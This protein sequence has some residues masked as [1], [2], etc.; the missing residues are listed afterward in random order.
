MIK[1]NKTLKK[2]ISET[3]IEKLNSKERKKFIDRV[4]STKNK[5]DNDLKHFFSKF[6]NITIDYLI[7]PLY[8]LKNNKTLDFNLSPEQIT[9]TIH[10][11]DQI[12]KKNNELTIYTQLLMINKEQNLN[13]SSEQIT[14]FLEKTDLFIQ[15]DNGW[16]TPMLILKY[17][18]DQNLNLSPNQILSIIE[19]SDLSIQDKNGLTL[20]MHLLSNNK[21][22]NLNLSP[23]QII[24]IIEK[25]DPTIKTKIEYS[26]LMF[27]L[28]TNKIQ[29][30]NLS[31]NQIF[32]LLKKTKIQD[33][34]II[35][36]I[37][38]NNKI[39]NFN[40]SSEQ[41]ST[42]IKKTNPLLLNNEIVT[43]FFL[44]LGEQFELSEEDLHKTIK[45]FNS[46]IKEIN[47][48][49]KEKINRILTHYN[50]KENIQINSTKKTTTKL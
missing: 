39:Q 43:I 32:T 30:I 38:R 18:K 45:F 27:L 26:L 24:P 22:Q 9:L 7:L 47:P 8:I 3:T 37:F 19:K 50:I 4:L 6:N 1:Q 36:H 23:D 40:F 25:S 35:K 34:K 49:N 12:I 17:N 20:P 42:I 13:F 28:L 46:T 31:T 21:N 11:L 41:I 16:T 14:T 10:Q 44:N 15:N 33:N 48:E 5:T 2:I 29:N